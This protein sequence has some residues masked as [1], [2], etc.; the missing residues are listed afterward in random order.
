MII[1]WIEEQGGWRMVEKTRRNRA[2]KRTG[3]WCKKGT[4]VINK[5]T[6]TLCVLLGRFNLCTRGC[7]SL[8]LREIVPEDSA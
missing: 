5:D 4:Y 3:K 2:V 1:H 8:F 7:A 6:W